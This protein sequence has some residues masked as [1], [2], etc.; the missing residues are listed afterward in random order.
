MAEREEVR[1]RTTVARKQKLKKAM[2]SSA[3]AATLQKRAR[4]GD[5]PAAPPRA[6]ARPPRPPRGARAAPA[7]L[8]R[9]PL[10]R[11]SFRV[12]GF[13]T[14]TA[15]VLGFKTRTAR[16][17]L[18]PRTKHVLQNVDWTFFLKRGR[19]RVPRERAQKRG[20]QRDVEGCGR[21]RRDTA[22]PPTAP[23]PYCPPYLAPYCSGVCAHRAGRGGRVCTRSSRPPETPRNAAFSANEQRQWWD[24]TP[25]GV[26]ML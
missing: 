23:L 9:V 24:A 5:A 11:K 10:R 7:P 2:P 16:V 21:M 25:L 19:R 6:A 17:F 1:S 26:S 14:R 15:R 12:L 18:A 20:M 22:P 13:K 4:A 3:L 8:P